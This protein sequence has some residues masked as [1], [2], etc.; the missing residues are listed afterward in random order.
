MSNTPKAKPARI[1]FNQDDMTIGELDDFYEITGLTLGVDSHTKVGA[2][3]VAKPKVLAAIAYI[4]RRRT[5]PT[6]TMD[7]ARAEKITAFQ[8]GASRRPPTPTAT[9]R[10]GRRSATSTRAT[11][12][13]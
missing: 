10:S 5:D 4:V 8:A 12:S 2:R 1:V 6:Y 13:P 3:S 11:P 7:D 9:S